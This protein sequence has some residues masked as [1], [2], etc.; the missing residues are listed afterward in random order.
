M[1]FADL[2]RELIVLRNFGSFVS[3]QTPTDTIFSPP[4]RPHSQFS[5]DRSINISVTETNVEEDISI[6]I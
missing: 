6:I 5:E 1:L 2:S 3:Q 4:R